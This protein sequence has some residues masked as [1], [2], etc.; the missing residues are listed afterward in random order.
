MSPGG[1]DGGGGDGDG[2]RKNLP[3]PHPTRLGKNM[4]VRGSP[5]SDYLRFR[6]IFGCVKV[7]LM[8]Y[9]ADGTWEARAS[10]KHTNL[11][12]RIDPRDQ[13]GPKSPKL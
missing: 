3:S 12:R 9:A 8:F 10:R 1:G 11:T 13:K 7:F 5:H 4:P 6:G 2:A